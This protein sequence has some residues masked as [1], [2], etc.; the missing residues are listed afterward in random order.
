MRQT[1]LDDI[2]KAMKAKD[3]ETLLTLRMVKGAIQLEEINK[4]K[5]LNDEE[6]VSI[7]A[8]QIKTRKESILEFAKGNRQDLIDQVN[9]EI[10]ILEKYMPVFMSEE[11]INKIINEVFSKLNIQD[12]KD[13]G[14]VMGTIMPLV[15]G[16]ADLGLVNSLVKEKMS[17]L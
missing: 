3:K 2:I 15:K 16:K 17:N 9:G 11:E 5:E 10:K 4:K 13:T 6:V 1:I 7:I 12:P 14:K 8:K